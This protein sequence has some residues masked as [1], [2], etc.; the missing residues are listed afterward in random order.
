MHSIST[1]FQ[2]RFVPCTK[3][4][5][6]VSIYSTKR[7]KCTLCN[8]DDHNGHKMVYRLCHCRCVAQNCPVKYCSMEFIENA[9][10]TSWKVSVG[11][12]LGSLEAPPVR[13]RPSPQVKEYVHAHWKD[14]SPVRMH[15]HLQGTC[16]LKTIQ[17]MDDVSADQPS[18]LERYQ[19]WRKQPFLQLLP[20]VSQ[21]QQVLVW[22]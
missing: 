8:N 22:K 1:Q 17:N 20:F 13:I 6:T 16:S 21:Q 11:V 2:P 7:P 19:R 3:P 4:T 5:Q 14:K 9:S 18:I 15:T 10:L 12:H